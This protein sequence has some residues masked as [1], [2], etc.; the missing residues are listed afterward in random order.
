LNCNF[1]EQF[2]GAIAGSNFAALKAALTD[3]CIET[4]SFGE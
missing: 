1:E 2:W 4:D 3:S